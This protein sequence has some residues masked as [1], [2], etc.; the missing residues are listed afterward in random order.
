MVTGKLSLSG[1]FVLASHLLMIELN[2]G[3]DWY[4][5][6]CC[7]LRVMSDTR[8]KSEEEEEEERRSERGSGGKMSDTHRIH[9]TTEQLTQCCMGQQLNSS[10]SRISSMSRR[11]KSRRR[12]VNG[13]R[14]E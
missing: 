1:S 6:Q 4:Q 13:V 5:L 2:T 9:S 3:Y 14:F 7:A 8:E 10:G 12:R 11:S